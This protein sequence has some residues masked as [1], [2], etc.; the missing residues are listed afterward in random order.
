MESKK[1]FSIIV[2]SYGFAEDQE[3]FK[4]D[5]FENGGDRKYGITKRAY[6]GID[7]K[8]LTLSE[9]EGII[10]KDFYQK[11]SLD[12]IKSNT[13]V[14]FILDTAIEYGVSSC[15]KMLQN[16]LVD[17]KLA[18][19][20]KMCKNT[21]KALNSIKNTDDFMV[22]ILIERH[23]FDVESLNAAVPKQRVLDRAK[24]AKYFLKM[25]EEDHA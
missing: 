23:L 6:P 13:L 1:A 12:Q 9:A 22:Q 24:R 2:D 15:I 20:G 19:N 3:H 10:N 7:L 8:K 17:S 11:L 18:I 21:L 16:A 14:V 25:K 4:K 5:V